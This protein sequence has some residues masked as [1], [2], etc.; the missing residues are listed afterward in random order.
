MSTD[1]KEKVNT[2][3]LGLCVSFSAKTTKNDK[4]ENL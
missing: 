1:T 3:E 4:V 2:R